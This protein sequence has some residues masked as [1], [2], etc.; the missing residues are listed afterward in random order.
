MLV[1]SAVACFRFSIGLFVWLEGSQRQGEGEEHG[2]GIEGGDEIVDEDSPA[3]G[4][5]LKS[6]GGVGLDDV[7]GAEEE[8]GEGDEGEVG[9]ACVE[10]GECAEGEGHAGG[11]V[12]DDVGGVFFAEVHFGVVGVGDAGEGEEQEDGEHEGVEDVG[13]RALGEEG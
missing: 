4:D 3:A 13:V 10:P 5:G 1:V 6:I 9:D 8:E 11:F 2:G 7:G 12:G